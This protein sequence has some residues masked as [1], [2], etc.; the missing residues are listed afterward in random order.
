MTEPVQ[1][2]VHVAPDQRALLQA[3]AE[4]NRRLNTAVTSL[5]VGTGLEAH[6]PTE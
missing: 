5:P 6:D 2:M 1:L 4:H 3:S